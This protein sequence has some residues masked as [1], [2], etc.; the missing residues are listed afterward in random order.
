MENTKRRGGSEEEAGESK[1]SKKGKLSR[2]GRLDFDLDVL[3]NL[4]EKGEK[5]KE[6]PEEKLAILRNILHTAEPHGSCHRD[7]MAEVDESVESVNVISL[8]GANEKRV[9]FAICYLESNNC[10]PG[11]WCGSE[12]E[13]SLHW[14]EGGENRMLVYGTF[15]GGEGEEDND[16]WTIIASE[17]GWSEV[18]SALG[19]A[20]KDQ[21]GLYLTALFYLAEYREEWEQFLYLVVSE[22]Q[23]DE[24]RNEMKVENLMTTFPQKKNG[25]Y[26]SIH[27]H[28]GTNYRTPYGD[29]YAKIDAT[30]HKF[31]SMQVLQDC[32]TTAA[33]TDLSSLQA[34][35]SDWQSATFE[36]M[37]ADWLTKYGF[38]P[39]EEDTEE[40]DCFNI[41]PWRVNAKR[42]C[43]Y[44]EGSLRGLLSRPFISNKDFAC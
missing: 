10:V 24:R 43:C 31:C 37:R 32:V 18:K 14:I 8:K 22:E 34:A 40:E 36:V 17:V 44:P 33:C 5:K 3:A 12:Y 19:L 35:L 23:E 7:W 27:S 28:G 29:K 25:S 38:G 21:L 4:I 39:D 9:V 2:E 6:K 30:H 1:Q 16:P 20:P 42:V 26:L 15:S 11:C 41:F 13:F